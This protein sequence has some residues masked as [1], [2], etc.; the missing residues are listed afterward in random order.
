MAT[1]YI[2]GQTPSTVVE[3]AKYVVK[4]R[5]E[6]A[7]ILPPELRERYGI[8]EGS[9]VMLVDEG[10]RVILLPKCGLEDLYGMAREHGRI[11]DEMIR[12]IAEEREL[13]A[14]S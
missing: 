2:P 3:L 5:E 14:R 9:E 4:V 13:E 6:G 8:E 10:G 11:I 12:E 1:L 7:I